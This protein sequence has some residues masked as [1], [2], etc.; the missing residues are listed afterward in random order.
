MSDHIPDWSEATAPMHSQLNELKELLNDKKFDDAESLITELALGLHKVRGWIEQSKASPVSEKQDG[1]L[2]RHRIY[3]I[4]SYSNKKEEP[5]RLVPTMRLRWV[6]EH[7]FSM[8]G[9]MSP[10]PVQILKQWFK[11][12]TTPDAAGHYPHGEWITVPTEGMQ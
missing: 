6:V 1:M 4:R 9:T 10:E 12:I 5:V 7:K 8:V 11:D 2:P 3:P